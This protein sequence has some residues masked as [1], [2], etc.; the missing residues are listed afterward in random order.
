MPTREFSQREQQGMM[1]TKRLSARLG[2]GLCLMLIA[3]SATAG[4]R[5][6]NMPRGVTPLSEQVYDLHMLIMWIC[7]AIGALVFGLILWSVFRHRKSRGV[8]AAQFHHNTSIE[9][10][11]TVVPMVILIA[12]AVPATR[13]LINM[14]DTSEAELTVKVT[15]YQWMW[16]YEYL[17]HGVQFLSRLDRESDRVRQL[18]SGLDPRSVDNYLQNVDQPLVLPVN[19]KVRFLLTSNDVIHSWWVPEFGWK[20]DAVPGFINEGWAII[21]EPGVY[22]GACAELC[23]RDHAFMPI[24]VV[25]LEEEEFD[26]WLAQR[27]NGGQPSS[28]SE[29]SVADAGSVAEEAVAELSMDELMSRGQQLYSQQCVACHQPNGQGMPPVFPALANSEFVTRSAEA[30]IQTIVKGR[31]AMPP[32]GSQFSDTEIAAVATFIRNNFGNQTGDLVQP[33]DVQAV[34]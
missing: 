3:S 4:W 26:E 9:I 2:L 14:A 1:V 8:E 27:R 29:D 22:R 5:A 7:A 20:R 18:G 6:L 30:V 32:F 33:A 15:G 16:G 25:A 11:W 28:N 23:G 10:V 34:R 12:M 31:N 13:T 24:V 17:D 21:R 19:R